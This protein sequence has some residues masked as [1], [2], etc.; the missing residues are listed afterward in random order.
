MADSVTTATLVDGLQIRVT[1]TTVFFEVV[2]PGASIQPIPLLQVRESS[3]A[4]NFPLNLRAFLDVDQS[5]EGIV[6]LND[7]KTWRI[8]YDRPSKAALMETMY[9]GK[10]AVMFSLL[11]MVQP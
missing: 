10:Y 4:N 1:D 11:Q 3:G 9:K 6:Y 8:R 7:E 2:V 5:E